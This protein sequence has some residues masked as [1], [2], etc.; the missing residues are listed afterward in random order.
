MSTLPTAPGFSP[1][2]ECS[3]SPHCLSR[4]CS[5]SIILSSFI[6]LFQPCRSH[7]NLP[8]FSSI[9]LL[10][11]HLSESPW[12]LA[13]KDSLHFGLST[14][15]KLFA[16]NALWGWNIKNHSTSSSLI[17]AVDLD[18]IVTVYPASQ[19][20]NSIHGCLLFSLG[21]FRFGRRASIHPSIATNKDGY[22]YAP[23]LFL[24]ASN[25]HSY[26]ILGRC[27]TPK[28]F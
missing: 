8:A 7:K 5:L 1:A 24:S 12:A 28:F 22:F 17:L 4:W 9:S 19:K 16:I 13:Q 20:W 14:R 11:W 3:F 25:P 23:L 18:F 26:F 6:C 2:Q 10:V 21:R 27:S 15:T